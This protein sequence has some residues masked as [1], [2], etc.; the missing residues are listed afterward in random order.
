MVQ[1][2]LKIAYSKEPWTIKEPTET[3]EFQLENERK[4]IDKRLD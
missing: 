3:I 4:N 1:C 2:F